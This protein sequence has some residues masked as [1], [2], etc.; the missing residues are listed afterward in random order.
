VHVATA[1]EDCIKRDPKGHYAK[2]LAGRLENF[3]GISDPYEI[4]LTPELRLE[5]ADSTPAESAAMVITR[6]EELGLVGVTA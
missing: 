1:V 5:T 4:P 2:A 6:I 3:T